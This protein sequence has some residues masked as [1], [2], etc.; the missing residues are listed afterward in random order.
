MMLLPPGEPSANTGLPS[1]STIVGAIEERGRFPGSTR[2]ATAASGGPGSKAKS[3]SWLL[4]RKPSTISREPNE[5]STDVVIEA[6]LP[7][8]STM[9][10]CEVDGSSSA[11]A[12]RLS[13]ALSQGGSP[14][15]TSS[16]PS[17]VGRRISALRALR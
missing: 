8:A 3:V 2:L 13:S 1:L 16:L 4:S 6:M 7:S 11:G 5:F 17:A 15:L 9:T 10:M 14:A 12:S